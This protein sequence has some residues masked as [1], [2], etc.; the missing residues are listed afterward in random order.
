VSSPSALVW[1]SWSSTTPSPKSAPSRGVVFSPRPSFQI[2]NAGRYAG[3]FEAMARC[4]QIVFNEMDFGLNERELVAEV[5]EAV[6]LSSVALQFGGSIPVVEVGD[7]TAEGM[8][9]RGRSTKQ[10]LEPARE[11]LRNVRR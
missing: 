5:S 9:G 2:R 10:G 3:G 7:G 6:V 4:R 11:W 1:T 8:E